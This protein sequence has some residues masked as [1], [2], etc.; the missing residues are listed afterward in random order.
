MLIS[1]DLFDLF[2]GTPHNWSNHRPLLALALRLSSIPIVL[3][4]GVGD[5]STLQLRELC[6]KI[7]TTLISFDSNNEWLSRFNKDVPEHH[8]MKFV[9]DNWDSVYDTL[10]KSPRSIGVAFIDHAPGERRIEDVR[11]VKELA[12]LVVVHDTEPEAPGYRMPEVLPTFKHRADVKTN[13]AWAS[14][15]SDYVDLSGLDGLVVAGYKV[16][17]E[18]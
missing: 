12:E 11:R 14:L 4:Y 9:G 18:R 1:D 17:V 13:G 8:R 16:E 6:G 10:P 15:V 7:G 5:G 2:V 3:E